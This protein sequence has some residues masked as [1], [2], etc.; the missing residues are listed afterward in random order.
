M[1]KTRHLQ[2]WDL[3]RWHEKSNDKSL[4]VKIRYENAV[5]SATSDLPVCFTLCSAESN[6]IVSSNPGIIMTWL[7]NLLSEWSFEQEPTRIHWDDSSRNNM[8]SGGTR[9][10]FNRCL[11]I[12]VRH[13]YTI[14]SVVRLIA[15][16]SRRK[17]DVRTD[18][19]TKLLLSSNLPRV[20]S[21]A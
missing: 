8:V 16:V 13:S 2:W 11:Y 17:K 21:A 6:H 10:L 20:I 9:E 15:N 3:Y 19:L 1:Y 7:Q 4:K 12:D 18:F 14:P 5:V